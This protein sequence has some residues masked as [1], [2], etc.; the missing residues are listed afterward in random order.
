MTFQAR[1][2]DILRARATATPL[3][4]RTAVPAAR[5]VF[6]TLTIGMTCAVSFCVAFHIADWTVWS[7][8]AMALVVPSL[9]WISGG[10]A[11]SLTGLLCPLPASSKPVENWQPAGQTAVLMM[12]CRE[13]SQKV[14]GSMLELS[15]QISKAG[16]TGHTRLI[17]LSDTFGQDAV[18]AEEA[19]LLPLIADG[20]ISY[21]RRYENTGRKP[22]NIAEWFDREGRAYAQMLVLDA[23]SRMSG[24]RLAR[25]IWR[26]ESQPGLGLLQAGMTL[27]PAQSRFGQVQRTASRLLG[28]PFSAGLA[29][30]TGDTANYWGHNALIRTAAFAAAAH[31]P[32]LSG[33]APF[34]GD[35]LSHDFIEAAFVR[36]TGWAVAFD[37]DAVGSAEDGP[38][39]LASFHRRNRRWCQGNLQ[40]IRLIATRGLNPLSRLHIASGIFSFLAA[41]VWL[42]LVVLMGSGLVVLESPLPFVLILAILLLPKLSG[43]WRLAGRGATAWRR[44]IALRAFGG[45]LLLSSLL[46]PIVMLHHTASVLA[47]LAGADCG[48]KQPV[49]RGV[50]L[51]TGFAEAATGFA[52]VGMAVLFNPEAAIWLVP[53]AGPMIAAPVLVR[54]M[55][56]IKPLLRPA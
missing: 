56:Q 27:V 43:L 4:R 47:V 2:S 30:W 33:P 53:V 52:L 7:V 51:P 6:I 29:A 50:R 15:R 26:M 23:D 34:G 41:P 5:R 46:A 16:L 1:Q 22:G 11:T 37:P 24:A 25:M 21:R 8:L 19:A 12:L 42:A 14:A 35:I 54:W 45:E 48:W 38:Q 17:V 3:R 32:R 10:A 31:L 9:L 39:E 36:R 13:D 28:P 20:R 40:H 55:D 18:A 44:R 49:T